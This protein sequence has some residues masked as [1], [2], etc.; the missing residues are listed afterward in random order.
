MVYPIILVSSTCV[1]VHPWVCQEY[2][3]IYREQTPDLQFLHTYTCLQD[4]SARQISF[5][6]S[7]SLT[8]IFK[9]TESNHVHCEVRTSLS[10]KR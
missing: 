3:I 2:T 1:C 6:S 8:F 10:R 7:T 5:K 4:T 9:V